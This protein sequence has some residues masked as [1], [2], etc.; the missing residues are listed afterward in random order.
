MGKKKE[1]EADRV[2][3]AGKPNLD[4]CDNK[5]VSARYTLYNFLPV[6]RVGV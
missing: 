2:L 4:R 6:V 1:K 5:V 3:L